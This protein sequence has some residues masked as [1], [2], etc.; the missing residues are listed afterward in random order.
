M[1]RVTSHS[2]NL[3]EGGRERGRER[4][5]VC[6]GAGRTVGASAVSDL[7]TAAAEKTYNT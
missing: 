6:W 5:A 2:T 1:L 4:L 3:A 7:K